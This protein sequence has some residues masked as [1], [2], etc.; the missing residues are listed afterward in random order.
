MMVE[1]AGHPSGALGSDLKIRV[2]SA[3][4]LAPVALGAAWMGGWFFAALLA[5]AALFMAQEVARL[6]YAIPGVAVGPRDAAGLAVAGLAAIV[7]ATAGLPGAALAAAGAVLAFALAARSWSGRPM[8]PALIAYSYLVVPLVAL[9][10][11]RND[12]E[13]GLAVILWLLATVWAIDICA[14]FAGR[15]IGGPKLAPSISPKKTWA[16]LAGGMIGAAAVG[17]VTSLWI[18]AGSPVLLALIGIGMTV[19]E[20][21][22]DFFESALKRHAGVKDSGTL[23]PGHGGILDRVDGLVA[24]AAGAALLALLHNAAHPGAGVLIWP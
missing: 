11:L 15:F 12:P 6:L 5:V 7:L 2:M 21:A 4:V 17:V 3:I 23:I 18:G 19:V 9:I 8:M 16:G 24:V 1:D 13:L 14:Y 10:W 22:G 20:Q